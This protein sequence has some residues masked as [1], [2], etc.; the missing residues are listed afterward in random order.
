MSLARVSDLYRKHPLLVEY[1]FAIAAVAIALV[2]SLVLA[3]LFEPYP[4]L[5]LFAAVTLSAWFGG[6]GPGLVAS[7]LSIVTVDVFF[8]IPA[9]TPN[10]LVIDVTRLIVFVLAVVILSLIR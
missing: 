9:H 3:G 5:L 8:L 2:L 10:L 1:G 4:F 6:F 7:L